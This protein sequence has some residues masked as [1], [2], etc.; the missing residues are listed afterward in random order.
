MNVHLIL[1]AYK[2]LQFP[3]LLNAL[4]KYVFSDD[5]GSLVINRGMI[6]CQGHNL[7]QGDKI[8][9]FIA[10]D[11]ILLFRALLDHHFFITGDQYLF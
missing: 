4:I 3:I 8:T 9:N 11:F 7:R 5:S 1:Y 2:Q 10:H 6:D